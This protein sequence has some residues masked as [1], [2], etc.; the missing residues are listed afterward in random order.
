MPQKNISLTRFEPGSPQPRPKS[1]DD[2]D[3]LAMGPVQ[4]RQLII[5][6][7]LHSINRSCSFFINISN[8]HNQKLNTNI[9]FLTEF[10]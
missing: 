5:I 9:W 2:L 10:E 4:R 8:L 6:T 7:G 1:L 3:H